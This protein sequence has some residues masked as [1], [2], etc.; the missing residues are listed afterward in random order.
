MGDYGKFKAD[1]AGGGSTDPA[2]LCF[3]NVFPGA[4]SVIP[5]V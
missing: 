1:R 5:L 2:R 4:N 3:I